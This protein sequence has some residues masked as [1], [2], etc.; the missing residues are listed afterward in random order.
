[1]DWITPACKLD[2]SFSNCE[3]IKLHTPLPS[4]TLLRS[5]VNP[6]VASGVFGALEY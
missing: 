2:G 3:S 5:P 4:V 6:A 1:M